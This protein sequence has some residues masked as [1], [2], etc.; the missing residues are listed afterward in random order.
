MDQTAIATPGTAH[1]STRGTGRW[2]RIRRRCRAVAAAMLGLVCVLALIAWPITHVR[3]ANFVLLETWRDSPRHTT[4]LQTCFHESP[5]V[6][7]LT[8]EA[9]R[10]SIGVAVLAEHSQDSWR[11][12]GTK[13]NRTWWREVV[14]F[15]P[16]TPPLSEL[17]NTATVYDCVTSI[18]GLQFTSANSWTPFDHRRAV[19][20]P[21]WMIALASGI[22]AFFLSRGVYWRRRGTNECMTCG[23]SRVGLPTNAA[24]PECGATPSTASLDETSHSA[25]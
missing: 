20:M 8:F 9:A 12:I 23:Y 2:R 7:E 1:T 24:C 3:G 4:E 18:A 11:W 5:N 10:G 13:Y 15:T 22:P 16:E 21:L 6:N 17:I 14:L 25:Q 19:V